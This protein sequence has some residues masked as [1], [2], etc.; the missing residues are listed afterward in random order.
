MAI[1]PKKINLIFSCSKCGSLKLM[2]LPAPDHSWQHFQALVCTASG[3][4]VMYQQG[5]L[6]SHSPTS[7]P[8]SDLHHIAG[9]LTTIFKN[10]ITLWWASETN[11]WVWNVKRIIVQKQENTSVMDRCNI[12]LSGIGTG[13]LSLRPWEILTQISPQEVLQLLI[14]HVFLLS[15]YSIS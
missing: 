11:I 5:V 9:L 1:A 6:I 13:L 15:S 4:H 7:P 2:A 12:S 3:R 8:G 14:S 10:I